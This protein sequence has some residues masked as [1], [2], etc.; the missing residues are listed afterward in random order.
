MALSSA[1]FLYV[2]LA[3]LIPS[4]RARRSL[5]ATVIEILLLAAGVATMRLLIH[6]H[7]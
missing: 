1:G 4:Q 2:A 7:D 6:A 5:R 3:D